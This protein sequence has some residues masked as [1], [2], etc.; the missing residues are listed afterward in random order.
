MWST[1]TLQRTLGEVRLLHVVQ[2]ETRVDG[3][4]LATPVGPELKRG[5]D[6]CLPGEDEGVG[7]WAAVGRGLRELV[8]YVKR[9]GGVCHTSSR[10]TPALQSLYILL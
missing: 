10:W 9:E 7:Q 1:K 4:P 5:Q 6:P 8:W 2:T 3:K